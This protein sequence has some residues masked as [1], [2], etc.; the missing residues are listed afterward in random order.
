MIPEGAVVTDK[1]CLFI[2]V[3]GRKD[4]LGHYAPKADKIITVVP[5][6]TSD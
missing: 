5:D 3:L 1:I 4:Y 6:K 2:G